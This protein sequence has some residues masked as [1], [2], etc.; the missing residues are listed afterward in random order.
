MVLLAHC[1][2]EVDGN[3]GFIGGRK[4]EIWKGQSYVCQEKLSL[5][6]EIVANLE[7]RVNYERGSCSKM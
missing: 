6:G 7:F 4:A 1:D 2:M 5:S 3:R